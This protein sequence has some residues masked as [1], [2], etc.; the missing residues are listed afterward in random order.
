VRITSGIDWSE[1][2]HHD[3]A[4][5]YENAVVMARARVTN[6]LG[7]FIELLAL[8]A[9]LASTG[10]HSDPQR[11]TPEL[12]VFTNLRYGVLIEPLC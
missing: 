6:D 3:V 7:G 10:Y 9:D 1:R 11:R 8:N 12:G 4:F 5:V 2:H